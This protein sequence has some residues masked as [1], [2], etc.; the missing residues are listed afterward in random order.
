VDRLEALVDA[1]HDREADRRLGGGEHDHEDGEDLAV[2]A[3]VSVARE[4]DV[5]DV[6]RIEDEL[7]AHED[8]DRVPP[9]EDAV[10]A[11]REEDRA[12]PHEVMQ[13]EVAHQAFT[14]FRD[15]TMA[16]T[17][18][19]R[20]TIE[21]TSKGRTKSVRNACPM[22]YVVGA[23]GPGS[24]TTHTAFRATWSIQTRTMPTTTSP[25]PRPTARLDTF[26]SEMRC[27]SMTANSVR[28]RIPPTY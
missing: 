26:T 17:S 27:V 13:A 3:P 5:V 16:P 8:A 19:A 24:F 15:T 1:E 14:S 4:G 18:A 22:P 2:V 7:D 9:R 21:A 10:E 12:E 20:R 28:T 11:E 25:A 6:G 23:A